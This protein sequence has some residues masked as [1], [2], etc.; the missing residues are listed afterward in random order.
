[1]NGCSYDPERERIVVPCSVR[2]NPSPETFSWS[3]KREISM[4]KGS[5]VAF[6]RP[7]RITGCSGSV[8]CSH[9]RAKRMKQTKMMGFM[10][11][12]RFRCAPVV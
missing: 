10:V 8:A 7:A 1:M 4:E 6:Q 9:P 12:L 11:H 3:A 2:K 5:V